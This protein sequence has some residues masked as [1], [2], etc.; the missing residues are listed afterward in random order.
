MTSVARHVILTLLIGAAAAPFAAAAEWAPNTWYAT[1]S[2]VTYQGP[3]YKCIQG[4]TSHTG[5]EPPNVP[6]LWALQQAR[7]T[8]RATARPTVR[9][10]TRPTVS[11]RRATPTSTQPT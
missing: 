10:T 11:P 7:P 6:A 5:W 2:L 3:T 1:D 4:H 8:P 9:P